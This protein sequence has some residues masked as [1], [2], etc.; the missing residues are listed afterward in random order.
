MP[1]FS[2]RGLRGGQEEQG[3]IEA[4]SLHAAREALSQAGFVV[5][6]IHEASGEEQRVVP[7][8]ERGVVVEDTK[9]TE[10]TKDSKEERSFPLSPRERDGVR[11]CP[12]AERMPVDRGSFL[13]VLRIYAGWL[14]A[15]Y[16]VVF[17]LGAYQLT[18][19]LP[20]EL[21]YVDSLVQSPLLPR[22]AFG[23]FLFLLLTTVHLSWNRGIFKGILLTIVGVGVWWGFHVSV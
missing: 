12:E 4:M 22:F 23:A 16:A 20:F 6:E 17:V 5:Q 13:S 19:R 8:W 15:W 3:S 1:V 2:Y 18:K 7:P 21:P 9:E 11:G 14:L 10:E